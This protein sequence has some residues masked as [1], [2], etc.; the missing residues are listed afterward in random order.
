M[1]CGLSGD[2]AVIAA[3]KD[4]QRLRALRDDAPA[5]ATDQPLGTASASVAALADGPELQVAGRLLE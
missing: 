3:Y 4:P 1:I 5:G 2:P